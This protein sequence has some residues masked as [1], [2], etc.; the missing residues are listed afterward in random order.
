MR[1]RNS[2][3]RIGALLLGAA[4]LAAAAPVPRP[5]PA[6]TF[7]NPANQ[8]TLLQSYKGQVVVVEFLLTRCPHCW[9]TSQMVNHLQQEL[10]PRGLQ[11]LAV[12]FDQDLT[13][14]RAGTFGKLAAINFPV[15]AATG[16]QVDAFLGRAA[17]EQFQVPQIVVID[18]AGVIRAQSKPSHESALENEADLRHIVEPLLAEK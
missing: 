2:M 1:V 10:G 12:A 7:N 5:A 11:A 16:E 15:G 13:P 18:R 17:G 9:R 4:L 14:A 6:F 3:L 8:P